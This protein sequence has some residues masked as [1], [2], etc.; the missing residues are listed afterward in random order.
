MANIEIIPSARRLI[1]SLRD[2]GYDFTQAVADVIDNSIAAGATLVAIDI[3]FDGDDSWVRIADNGCGMKPEMLR[4]A[5][6]FGSD[7]TYKDDDLGKFGLGLKT[8]SLSQCQCLSVASRWNPDRADV[9]AY[10]WDLDHIQKTDKWEIVPIDRDVVGPSIRNVLKD[11]PGTVVLWHRL[12]RLLGYKHPY[13]EAARKRLQ[14][15]CRDLELHLG[16]VFERFLSSK[17]RTKRLKVLLNGNQVQPWDPFCR[18]EAK[19][20]TLQ[21]IELPISYEGTSGKVL[22]EPFV[23]PHQEDFSTQ[24]AFRL[25]SGPANWNQQQGFYVYR[26][27][28]M[29]QSGGWSNLR[30]PDEHTKLARV[31]ISFPPALDEAFKINVAKMRVQMPVGIREEIKKAITSVVKIARDTYDRRGANARPST[32]PSAV[33]RGTSTN[34]AAAQ[35]TNGPST[36]AASGHD[37]AASSLPI[38]TSNLNRIFE[39]SPDGTTANASDVRLS[40]QEW[41]QRLTRH[42]TEEE[43][44]IIDRVLRR[45]NNADG[46]KQ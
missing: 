36:D 17:S 5:L 3:E 35:R 18:S 37:K 10:A 20:K 32:V 6:R 12:D 13:G 26:A 28:R 16:M 43:R 39:S 9:A 25:A 15:M 46:I 23:L 42:A 40:R 4:E 38:H 27:N 22:I 14:E 24:E 45:M 29:I 21:S 30:A 1:R 8:A 2:M 34:S 7:R 44:P 31:A 41:E 33:S 19:T 11:G